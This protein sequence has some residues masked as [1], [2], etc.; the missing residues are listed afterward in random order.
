[1]PAVPRPDKIICCG[2][3]YASHLEEMK[4]PREEWPKDI[5]ISFMKPPT[6]LVGHGETVLYPPDSLKWDY[7]NELTIVIGRACSDVSEADADRYIF[8]YTIMNDACVRDTPAWTGRYDSPRGKAGDSHAPL[9]HWIAPRTHL[10]GNPND[11]RI[12]TTVDGDQRQDCRTSGLL[13]PVQHI[14]AFVSRY[15]RLQPGDVIATGSGPG[16]AL[17]SGRYLQEGQR[18]RCEIEGIGVIENPVARRR[19]RSVMLTGE[20][21]GR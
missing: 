12:L 3:S 19:W 13:F 5:K 10:A 14:T 16:N 6:A 1:M 18:V 4:M 20:S 17:R 15:I 11:L 7:E 9:G 2:N 8:G 21:A